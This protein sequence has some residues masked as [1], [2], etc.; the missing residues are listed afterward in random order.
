MKLLRLLPLLPLL[1][2]LAACTG[3]SSQA[4]PTATPFP[5]VPPVPTPPDIPSRPVSFTTSDHL[6]LVGQLYGQGKTWVI[7]S[8]MN[9]TTMSIWSD[10]GI[11]QRLA[12]MGYQVLLY[13]FRGFGS[14]AGDVDTTTLD[15]DLTASVNYAQKQGA[16]KVVLLGASMGGTASLNVAANDPNKAL[17]AAVISL[18]G[19][20]DFGVDVTDAQLK[21][22]TIPKLFLA[23]VDDDT[24][25]SDAQHMYDIASPPK[26]I[27]LYEGQNHGTT[28]LN[29]NDGDDPALRILHFIQKYAPAS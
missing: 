10:S 6:N 17:I 19:P 22:M 5:T 4:A 11:P 13:D 14:S 2:M 12:A 8:H 7:C 3:I 23:S 15:V 25:G 24:F 9:G 21:V 20:Q 18:S 26:E 16:T 1:L 29:S 28:I 27:H